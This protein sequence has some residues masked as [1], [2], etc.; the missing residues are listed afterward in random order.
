MCIFF[1]CFENIMKE[2]SL[3]YLN[4]MFIGSLPE[5]KKRRFPVMNLV[6]LHS[7][8]GYNCKS[9]IGNTAV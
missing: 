2:L 4:Y 1:Y 7:E 9:T 6:Q 5:K 8:W 3:Y